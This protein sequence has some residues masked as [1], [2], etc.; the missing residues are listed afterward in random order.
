[1]LKK[2]LGSNPVEWSD[3]HCGTWA[4]ASLPWPFYHRMPPW[5]ATPPPP[6]ERVLDPLSETGAGGKVGPS[7]W[8]RQTSG[9]SA[10]I[11]NPSHRGHGVAVILYEG[12]DL[13]RVLSPCLLCPQPS[14]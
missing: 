1:M 12:S 6:R 10:T 4:S 9:C 3:R 13:G 2:T 8:G 7:Q 14:L 11:L 5:K